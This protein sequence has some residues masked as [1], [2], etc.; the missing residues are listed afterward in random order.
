MRVLPL[1]GFLGL[2]ATACSDTPEQA[3]DSSESDL[4]TKMDEGCVHY[5]LSPDADHLVYGSCS[6]T[7]P[8][9]VFMNLQTG[10][11]V[12]STSTI[13]RWGSGRLYVPF[14]EGVIFQT[15]A[16]FEM[17]D[18]AGAKRAVA[19]IPGRPLDD[20]PYTVIPIDGGAGLMAW[21]VEGSESAWRLRTLV[22]SSGGATHA[23]LSLPAPTAEPIRSI[24]AAPDGSHLLV[25]VGSA[26]AYRVPTKTATAPSLVA[27]DVGDP[28][29]SSYDG[30]SMLMSGR[31]AAHVESRYKLFHLDLTTQVAKPLSNAKVSVW[32]KDAGASEKGRADQQRDFTTDH[33]LPPDVLERGSKV[34]FGE[35]DLEHG[36]YAVK[37]WNRA[38]PAAAP[39]VLASESGYV[40]AP[41]DAPFHFTADGAYLVYMTAAPGYPPSAARDVHAVRVDGS[42]PATLVGITDGRAS[43]A[44]GP[45]A[46][47]AFS[48]TWSS[49]LILADLAA[50]TTQAI[51]TNAPRSTGHVMIAKDGST[52]FNDAVWEDSVGK[53]NGATVFAGTPGPGM[54]SVYSGTGLFSGFNDYTRDRVTVGAHDLFVVER[55]AVTR[56]RFERVRP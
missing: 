35:N 52:I 37:A 15:V 53:L 19:S 11:K 32:R 16:G 10:A 49:T 31:G 36:T 18:W 12:T 22:A 33:E 21:R 43:V 30:T 50:G 34:Y 54:R 48:A 2:L 29:P 39:V 38:T 9:T 17:F 40:K 8:A 51:S 1:L 41:L 6:L 42:S 3:V 28:I 14:A 27:R 46:T 23:M 4:N 56:W 20:S 55:T 7:S 45:A 5:A 13:E 25:V 47:I 26:D 24:V 44:M